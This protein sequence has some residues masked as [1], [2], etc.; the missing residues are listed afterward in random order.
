MLEQV[1]YYPESRAGLISNFKM[2]GST[3]TKSAMIQAD[4]IG[5][6]LGEDIEFVSYQEIRY[7]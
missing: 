6:S 3:K 7:R 4:Q 5:R 2:F 1:S